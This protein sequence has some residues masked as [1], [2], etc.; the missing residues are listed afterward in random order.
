MRRLFVIAVLT[1]MAAAAFAQDA[2]KNNEIYGAVWLDYDA[3]GARLGDAPGSPVTASNFSFSRMRFGL[4]NTLADNVKSWFEFDPRNLEFRQ[5]NVDWSPVAGLDLVAGKQ[6][7]LFAQNNDWIFGD[8]TLGLQAR[9]TL[10][11]LGWGGDNSG[12]QRRYR[13]LLQQEARMGR[14]DRDADH[15]CQRCHRGESRR[16]HDLSPAH[17]ETRPR[18]G[19]RPGSRRQ[20]GDRGRQAGHRL[21]DRHVDQRLPGGLGVRRH[22]DGRIHPDQPQRQ[23]HGEPGHGALHEAR[24]QRRHGVPHGVFRGRQRGGH[25]Q[26]GNWKLHQQRNSERNGDAGRSR[27]T[28]RKTW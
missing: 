8:R 27:S 20:R 26:Q 22:A 12:Q 1:L 24:I 7:K 2:P 25:E 3:S 6:A 9:Y 4:R 18:Q 14:D 23:H 16:R 11:G 28:R 15:G 10:P 19:H 21:P 5:V 13:E 17:R